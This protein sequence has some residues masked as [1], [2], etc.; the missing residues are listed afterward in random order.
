VLGLP[1][2]PFA[3]DGYVTCLDL[4]GAGALFTLGW[5]RRLVSAGA[6]GKERKQLINRT[7]ISP[8][9]ERERLLA[10]G[11]RTRGAAAAI[12]RAAR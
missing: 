10:A 11:G 5:E 6:E 8:P 3:Y 12:E 7:L 9:R 2:E 1:T 4:G